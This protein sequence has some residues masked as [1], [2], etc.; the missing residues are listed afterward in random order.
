[1][2]EDTDYTPAPW[3]ATDSFASARASYDAHVGRSYDDA[4]SKGIVASDLVP[5]RMLS[6]AL[7]PIAILC[8][9]T[10]SMGAWPAT[11]FS[12]L[13]YLDHEC[14]SYFGADYEILFGAFGD[15]SYGGEKY[16]VQMRPFA[17]GAD[18][19]AHLK[20]L[21]IEGKGG[22]QIR[23]SAELAAL[24]ID[25]NVDVPNAVKPM[26]IIITDEK[27]YDV[28]AP[29]QAKQWC[30]ADIAQRMT[31]EELF[32]SLKQKWSVYLIRKPYDTVRNDND[33][34]T[35]TNREV[36]LYWEKLLGEDHIALLP[37]ASRVVDVI[38]GIF[39]KEVGRVSDFVDEL[40]QRQAKDVGGDK[41][42]ATALKALKTIHRDAVDNKKA[43]PGAK[44]SIKK[45]PDHQRS[46]MRRDP[47]QK[48][49]RG[50]SLLDDD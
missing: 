47:D 39:A 16:P 36:R 33:P 8:D 41:K 30:K 1:M 27:A 23:E 10:G 4:L 26:L 45:L 24:Y 3:A 35:S 38:F 42:I 19:Q 15:A 49:R 31:I 46:Q 43:L 17:K 6:E 12:K 48:S 13:G 14:Q 34:E 40:T 29:D 5:D 11:I 22:G 28:I 25:R 32:A 21:V 7:A 37:D 18:L 50:K 20:E 2:P 9:Q 44:S